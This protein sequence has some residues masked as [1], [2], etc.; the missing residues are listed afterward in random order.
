MKQPITIVW[1]KRDLRIQD[2]QP[3]YTAVQNG[4]VLPLYIIEP[5]IIHAPDY[6]RRHYDFVVDCLIDLREQLRDRGQPLIVRVGE[7]IDTL[8]ALQGKFDIGAIHAHQEVGNALTYT[9]DITVRRWCEEQNISFIE[10]PNNGVIRPLNDRNQRRTLWAEQISIPITPIPKTLISLEIEEGNIPAWDDLGIR[11]EG[12]EYRQ[13]G[14][15]IEA[16][17]VLHT[18]LQARGATYHRDMSSPL[19]APDSCSRLSTHLAY[20]TL[21]LRQV[22]NAVKA[23]RDGLYTMPTDAYASLDGNFK[24]AMKAFESRIAWRD[25][26]IQKLEDEPRIEFESFVPQYDSLRDNPEIDADANIRWNALQAGQTGFPMIDAC[27]RYLRATGWINF[28][29]RALLMSFASYHL[30]IKWQVTSVWLARLFTDYEPGIHYSQCQMQS[31]ATGINTLRVYSPVKQAQDQDPEGIFIREWVPELTYVPI[32]YI[33]EPHTMPP[34]TQHEAKCLIGKDYPLPI[35][36]HK[37]ASKSA[38]DQIWALRKRDDV[39]AEAQKV[40][41]RHGSRKGPR[42][43]GTKT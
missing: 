13:H 5:S 22:Y 14:G 34:M 32:E 28:R 10:T 30:W 7:I 11:D 19:T 16:H 39:K 38:K 29:M 25:H 17:H 35:I 31:G 18:F 20:G 4:A 3:L 2:H 21:S 36:D 1:F 26:F 9:R 43:F 42:R 33:H 41:E 23:R 27:V 12:I 40:V 6:D 37:A 24:Q 8:V 15:E